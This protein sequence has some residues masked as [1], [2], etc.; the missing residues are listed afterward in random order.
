MM[1]RLLAALA[2]TSMAMPSI[3]AAAPAPAGGTVAVPATRPCGEA[4]RRE[5]LS[6]RDAEAVALSAISPDRPAGQPAVA[7]AVDQN[8]RAA[9]ACRETYEAVA[10]ATAAEGETCRWVTVL[11]PKPPSGT[12]R[13]RA[14]LCEPQEIDVRIY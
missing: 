9:T 2:A 1:S 10:T 12:T 5:A 13:A 11:L 3:A 4:A 7:P 6:P 8:S 14:W